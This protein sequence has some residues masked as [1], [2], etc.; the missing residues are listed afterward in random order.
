MKKL[1]VT[2]EYVD[3][4]ALWDA[5]SGLLDSIEMDLPDDWDWTYTDEDDNGN[6]VVRYRRTCLHVEEGGSADETIRS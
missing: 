1:V 3:K 4:D 5:V 2:F 6:E